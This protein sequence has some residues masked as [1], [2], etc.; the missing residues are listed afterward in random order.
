MVDFVYT[1]G[2]III[3]AALFALLAK[4]FNQPLLL[5]YV[6][7]GVVL[8]PAVTGVVSD[9]AP[10]MAFFAEFGLVL[11]LFVIGLEL[12]LSKIKSLGMVSIMIG[13][14]QVAL[15]TAI[16]WLLALL[17]GFDMM[18]AVYTGLIVAFSSTLVVVKVLSDKGELTTLHGGMILGILIVEDILAVVGLTLLGALAQTGEVSHSF[19]TLM[20]L[21]EVAGIHIPSAAWFSMIEMLINA[22]LFIFVAFLFSKYLMPKIFKT[23]VTSTELLFAT[24]FG[25]AL[26]LAAIGAFFSFSFAI[27]AFVAGIAL[28]SA[29]FSHE[30]MGKVKP[31]KDFI[32]VL[33]FVAL[34]TLLTFSNFLQQIKLIVFLVVAAIILKPMIIF[35][36][37]KAF[38]Y[39]NRVSFL[40][41]IGLAQIS[42]F[43]LILAMAGVAQGTLATEYITGA[44]I[45]T[46]FSMMLTAYF[47]N[48]D[49]QL[50]MFFKQILAPVENIFGL[51][52][53][54]QHHQHEKQ[55]PQIVILGINNMSI[56]AIEQLHN[57][58]LLLIEKN[59]E[60]IIV[61]KERG[62]PTLCT[63]AYNQ[64]LY[65]EHVDFSAV[66]TVV[67]VVD[68]INTNTYFIRK[69]REINKKA[70]IVV[71]AR[72]EEH[73]K[74]LYKVGATLVMVPDVTSRR[75]LSELLSLDT[76]AL[77][78]TGKTY[79]Q[80]L[81]KH[82]VYKR[83]L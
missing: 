26:T 33:F 37:R 52:S 14:V 24:S 20:H 23:A 22:S 64:D 58:K 4:R 21:L 46:L 57:K 63:D 59:P 40:I 56:E 11:L 35:V 5:G 82:F 44:V 39:N 51:R 48:Y 79:Y 19:P 69:I 6:L 32:L 16:V 12:D 78:D 45:A 8:G 47:I 36:V 67:S 18:T 62:I 43:S 61:L 68:A 38:K 31:V 70:H 65:D 55:K 15:I 53:D 42:E 13:T 49:E 74:R 3:V 10:L 50:Y 9:P 17:A 25:I 41:S 77:H 2:L 30:V 66:E 76:K 29:P 81:Q 27:G 73:G 60:K 80:E 34:G 7:A 75:M 72:T 28:S 54:E 83:E 71:I 1:L